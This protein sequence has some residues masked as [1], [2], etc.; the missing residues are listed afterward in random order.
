MIFDV[1]MG[2][3][4]FHEARFVA[5]GHK[6]ETPISITYSTV[7]FWYSARICLTIAAL[8]NIHVLAYEIENV[9]LS[10]PCCEQVLIRARPE[11]S[12][13]EGKVVIITKTLYG[14]KSS[15][16]SFREFLA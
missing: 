14:L 3:N 16:E 11:F 2:E 12:N 6:T 1:N 13:F 7:V 15:G 9:Y 10:A 5:E 8:N 4:F